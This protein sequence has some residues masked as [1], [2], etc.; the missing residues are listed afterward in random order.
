MKKTHLFNE[1]TEVITT[2][3]TTNKADKLGK[4]LFKFI[5][6]Y[7]LIDLSIY[8]VFLILSIIMFDKVDDLAFVSVDSYLYL[9]IGM[10]LISLIVGGLFLSLYI[11]NRKKN[12]EINITQL[13]K[14][15]KLY[16]I[17][18]TVSFVGVFL[19]AFLWL[20]IFV[21]TPVEVSGRSMETTFYDKDKI[22]VWHIGYN[23]QLDDV[24]IV[25]ANDNYDFSFD[26]NF[27]IK[28]CVAKS[29]DI[30]TFS[31]G[32]IKVNG[33]SINKNEVFTFDEYSRMMQ[34]Y[35]SGKEYFSKSQD[36]Y[37]GV[38][39]A[40]YC[41]VLGDNRGDSVDSRR[42]GLIH[43]EDVLGKVIF[44]VYPFTKFGII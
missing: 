10:L 13:K 19:T 8:L 14:S 4:E 25:D 40:G 12:K 23:P 18:D 15:Y 17:F 3:D 37:S 31:S 1:I 44:R 30:V 21:I 38:V 27:V 29:G 2:E 42:V 7:C 16:Q 22:L 34:D 43:N 24:V 41:I 33:N 35:K 11:Y 5:I 32:V 39:P 26:T 20:T 28:R 9:V 36:G 6:K